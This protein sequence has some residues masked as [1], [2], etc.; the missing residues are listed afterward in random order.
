MVGVKVHFII[1]PPNNFK[2]RTIKVEVLGA[3]KV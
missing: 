3:G 1:S 2:D